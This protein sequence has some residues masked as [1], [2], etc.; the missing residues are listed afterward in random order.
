M[1]DLFRKYSVLLL[2]VFFCCT[3]SYGQDI[4]P[5]SLFPSLH[6][7]SEFIFEAHTTVGNHFKKFWNFSDIVDV[8]TR[9]KRYNRLEVSS[10]GWLTDDG[11]AFAQDTLE[12]A[13]VLKDSLLED[14]VSLEHQE[15]VCWNKK[16]FYDGQFI[17][18]LQMF[19]VSRMDTTMQSAIESEW[20]ATESR[21]HY[22]AYK[23]LYNI[24]MREYT[25]FSQRYEYWTAR[26]GELVSK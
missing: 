21:V 25:F 14:L 13:K 24:L 19:S 16:K 3:F 7:Y 17:S 5:Q 2:G 10:Y 4:T 9:L 12:K 26:R 1:G 20:C 23:K 8:I 18:A 6:N 15:Q 11:Y 22:H